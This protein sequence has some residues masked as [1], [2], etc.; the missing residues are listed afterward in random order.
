VS[1]RL[2]VDVY[3]P[4]QIGIVLWELDKLISALR[5]TN[6]RSVVTGSEPVAAEPHVSA[7]LLGVLRTSGISERDQAALES[8]QVELQ[9]V[10]SS[11]PVA[12]FLLSALP[13]RNFKR[14]LVA[15]C[16]QNLH[17]N[18]LV[19]FA[20]RGD[21]GGGFVLRVGSKQYDF[22]YRAQLLNDKKR[23]VEI[24]DNVR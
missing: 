13:N 23:L 6:T 5:D 15:W 2:P 7:L 14:E 18:L 11:A 1:A 19:T 10:R 12:H 20:T 17:E 9:T 8:L 3:S 24:F 21:L 16:R 22:T 4:D